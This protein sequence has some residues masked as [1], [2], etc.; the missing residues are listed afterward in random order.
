MS[1]PRGPLRTVMTVTRTPQ[2][3]LVEYVE[4]EHI[5]QVVTHMTV[6]PGE[7]SR[8]FACRVTDQDNWL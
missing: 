3:Q 4:C 6:K 2:V 7:K 5:G 1:D 8:C